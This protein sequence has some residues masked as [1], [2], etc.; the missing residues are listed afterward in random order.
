MPTSICRFG[1]P[2]QNSYSHVKA[3]RS[4]L[5]AWLFSISE[6]NFLNSDSMWS[7]GL[8]QLLPSLWKSLCWDWQ[9]HLKQ[10]DRWRDFYSC[11]FFCLKHGI[12]LVDGL[13]IED[14]Q[15]WRRVEMS[16]TGVSLLRYLCTSIGSR[17]NLN[18]Y[19]SFKNSYHN[20]F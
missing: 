1:F 19:N 17:L 6:S 5:K 18:I 20:N 10:F 2:L 12:N 11:L 13:V 3:V 8:I 4:R 7:T 14:V 15:V 16:T 9:V